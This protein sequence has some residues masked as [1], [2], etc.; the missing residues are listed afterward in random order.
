ML[1]TLDFSRNILSGKLPDW[2]GDLSK[3]RILIL[4]ANNFEGEIPIQVGYLR[5]L[6]ILDLAMNHLPGSIPLQLSNLS[7]MREENFTRSVP[8]DLYGLSYYRDSNFVMKKG[9][10]MAYQYVD[11]WSDTFMDLSA[12]S[13]TAH[14]VE[15]LGYLKGLRL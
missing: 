1:T 10:E 11:L 9:Q 14:I 12:N 5:K 8:T 15:Q 3:L 13:L 2:I 4:R 7:V 6:Q